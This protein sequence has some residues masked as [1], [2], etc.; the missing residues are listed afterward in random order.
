MI[1]RQRGLG[2]QSCPS[3]NRRIMV[4]TVNPSNPINPTNP[5]SDSFL[6]ARIAKAIERDHPLWRYTTLRVGGPADL[7]FRATTSDDLA[8]AVAAAQRAGV[9]YFLLGG[10]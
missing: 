5:R 3:S 6:P 7:Y 8:E 1:S 9:P 2:R 10:G 4:Q